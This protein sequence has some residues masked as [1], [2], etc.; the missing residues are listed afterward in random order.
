MHL[1]APFIKDE[2]SRT[3]IRALGEGQARFV[4]GAVRDALLGRLV[5]DVDIATSHPPD[6]VIEKLKAAG[7]KAVPTGIDHGTI[8]AIVAHQPFEV[9]SLRHDVKTFGRHAQ[10]AFIDDWQADARRRDFTMN[11]LYADLDGRLYDYHGG[12]ADARAGRIVFIGDP[13]ER[14]REDALRILRFF[15]FFAHY[16]K[17]VPHAAGYEACI[18]LRDRLDLLSVERIRA[19]LLRLLM[20]PDPVPTLTLMEQGGILGH[21]LPEWHISAGLQ[22]LDRLVQRENALDLAD[23]LRRLAALLRPETYERLAKRFKLSRADATRLTAMT[24]PLPDDGEK[25]VRQALWS[26][27]ARTLVDRFLLSDKGLSRAAFSDIQRWRRPV[28]PLQGRDLTVLGIQPGPQ[29]GQF[30][31]DAEQRWVTSDFTLKKADLLAA[32]LK[33]NGSKDA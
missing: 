11:A 1:S 9:T 7:L 21:V 12:V 31:K 27:G 14:I 23:P 8:T 4:G 33:K 32:I 20:A 3:V 15:R 13:E 5:Q 30:L 16:G 24:G 2:K 25:A 26:D 22:A 28:F 19:E 10:V 17:G 18:A 6:V 29:M